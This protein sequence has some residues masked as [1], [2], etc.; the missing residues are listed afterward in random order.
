M[1]PQNTHPRSGILIKLKEL[2]KQ[3]VQEGHCD[4]PEFFLTGD[5]ALMGKVPSLY[6]EEEKQSYHRKWGIRLRNLCKPTLLH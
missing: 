6:Q 3:Q 5:K 2:E 4:F 1:S